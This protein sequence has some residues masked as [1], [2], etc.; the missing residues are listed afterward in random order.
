MRFCKMMLIVS[1]FTLSAVSLL[2]AC[3]T[4]QT[5]TLPMKDG[6]YKIIATAVSSS[7]AN[8]G[9]VKTAKKVC[10]SQ[11]K[12]FKA[13]SINTIY[14]GIGKEIGA[15]SSIASDVAWQTSHTA[16]SS[17]RT[18]EDYQTTLIFSCD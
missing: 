8:A 17:T 13:I 7:E 15:L 16:V 9:A 12:S 18:A 14:Q 6:N 5:A 11:G 10:A 2:T 3:S 1:I 4:L